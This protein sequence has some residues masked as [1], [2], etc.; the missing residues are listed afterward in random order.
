MQTLIEL[1]MK[2]SGTQPNG[3]NLDEFYDDEAA[4]DEEILPLSGSRFHSLSHQR[5]VTGIH[6]LYTHLCL[7]NDD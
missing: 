1:D 7:R 2:E 6:T 5:V 4:T 3:E